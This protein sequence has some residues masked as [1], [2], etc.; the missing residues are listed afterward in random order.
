MSICLAEEPS[1]SPILLMLSRTRMRTFK[2]DTLCLKKHRGIVARVVIHCPGLLN[3]LCSSC[4]AQPA[5]SDKT[6]SSLGLSDQR[7]VGRKVYK[8][9][10]WPQPNQAARMA[11]S[12]VISIQTADMGSCRTRPS[13]SRDPPPLWPA[14]PYATRHLAMGPDCG[15]SRHLLFTG[16]PREGS[17]D[18]HC[19]QQGK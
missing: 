3:G 7:S 18:I 6:I 16:G 4:L 13:K 19:L 14:N 17:V 1:D 9:K 10:S 12:S 5:L 11:L 8:K 15:G 2:K